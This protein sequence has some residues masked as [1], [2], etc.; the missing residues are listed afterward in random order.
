M[1]RNCAGC[2]LTFETSDAFQRLGSPCSQIYRVRRRHSANTTLPLGKAVVVFPRCPGGL[3]L[4]RVKFG[5]G[6]VT[7]VLVQG[8]VRRIQRAG[9]GSEHH[10]WPAVTNCR[11]RLTVLVRFAA[12]FM[13]PLRAD[14]A[15]IVFTKRAMAVHPDH[16]CGHSRPPEE[17]NHEVPSFG[18]A[19]VF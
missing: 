1:D 11:D 6:L 14:R 8:G 18:P 5:E 3:P 17:V 9:I 7:Q 4:G 15:E 13:E 10:E 19:G 2:R 12:I 16:D